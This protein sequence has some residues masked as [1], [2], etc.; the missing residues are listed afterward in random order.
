MRS[1]LYPGL[2][3]STIKCGHVKL[4]Y[5]NSLVYE[6]QRQSHHGL[7]ISYQLYW[8]WIP[9]CQFSKQS[10]SLDAT[11]KV[12]LEVLSISISFKRRLFQGACQCVDII[13]SLCQV[14]AKDWKYLQI[15][16]KFMNTLERCHLFLFCR[17]WRLKKK[18]LPTARCCCSYCMV[19]LMP[20]YLD[21]NKLKFK[22]I[23]ICIAY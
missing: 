20:K 3:L 15:G 14:R 22:K 17:W 4:V 1:A 16:K 6:K 7:L 11:K 8:P 2:P 21:P 9:K 10:F 13:L 23:Y 19:L 12:V 18:C 5:D